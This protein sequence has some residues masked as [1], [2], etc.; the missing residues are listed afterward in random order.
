[1]ASR[2]PAYLTTAELID[3]LETESEGTDRWHRLAR[4]AHGRAKVRAFPRHRV[5]AT[6]DP[7]VHALTEPLDVA[8]LDA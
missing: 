6:Y 1:M 2:S 8:D 4:E 5:P 3:A 7:L